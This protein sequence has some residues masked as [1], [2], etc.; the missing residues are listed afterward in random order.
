MDLLSI[1]G[2]ILA[3][4][5]ILLGNFMEGGHLG[6]LVNVPALIIVIGGTTGCVFTNTPS[7]VVAFVQNCQMGF[8]ANENRFKGPDH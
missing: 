3:F 6:A 1:V 5:A 4:G 7:G 8:H 2:I